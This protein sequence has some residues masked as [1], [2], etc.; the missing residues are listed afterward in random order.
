MKQLR[1]PNRATD[2]PPAPRPVPG[3]P[4]RNRN[5]QLVHAA[6]LAAQQSAQPPAPPA[7]PPSDPS[8][9]SQSVGL[10]VKISNP[11][12]WSALLVAVIGAV[13]AG[14][15]KLDGARPAREAVANIQGATNERVDELERKHGDEV[16]RLNTVIRALACRVD[17]QSSALRRLGYDPGFGD[18]VAWLSQYL[19]DDRRPR[20][21]PAW[22]TNKACPALPKVPDEP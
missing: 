10:Q 9:K 1:D 8:P 17:V 16:K 7:D 4:D 6:L 5:E 13:F 14:W 22:V 11:V 15:A 21:Q 12:A 3:V 18:D 20:K 2:P 19:V